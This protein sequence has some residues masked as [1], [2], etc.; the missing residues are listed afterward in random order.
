MRTRGLPCLCLLALACSTP[1]PPRPASAPTGAAPEV[2]ADLPPGSVL[3]LPPV[4]VVGR[5]AEGE[6]AVLSGLWREAMRLSDRFDVAAG[7][8]DA[9]AP[10]SVVV[11]LDA[12]AATLTSSLYEEGR[13]PVAL[14]ATALPPG[15]EAEAIEALASQTRYALG[16]TTPSPAARLRLLYSGEHAC[17]AATEAALAAA[18]DGD[19]PDARSRLDDARRADAGCTITLLA[20]AELSLRANDFVRARR[21]AQD[22]LQLTNRGAP[23]TRH[24]LARVLLLARAAHATGAETGELDR[25]LLALGERAVESRPHDPHTRWTLAQA[26]SLVGRFEEAAPMLSALRQR[27]PQ[28]TQVPYHHAL[29][30]LGC[31][32]P[33]EALAAL[34]AV[35]DRLAPTQTAIPHAIALWAAGRQQELSRL[36]DDLVASP[37]VRT[38]ALL[39]H[40]R[41]MQAAQAILEERGDDA[42]RLLL[43]DLEWMRQR[44][45]RLGTYAEQLASTGQVLV[46]LG[47]A[48]EVT[49]TVAAFERLPQLDEGARRALMFAGGL[50]ATSSA[51]S[52]ASTAEASLGK[53]GESAWSLQLRAAAHRA[54]GELAEEARALLQ[55]AR[56]DRGPLLRA[57]LAR[58]LRTAGDAAQAKSILDA[59][60]ADLLRLDLRRLAAH[61]LVDPAN[62]LALLATR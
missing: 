6:V 2:L 61:P 40:V 10:H 56:L 30:L 35:H 24:R 16:D 54:R 22:A 60:R 5:T 41:R 14:A 49:R 39:H 7:I 31:D 1:Q 48:A 37:D 62:A 43:T 47:H 52:T 18:V 21:V 3:R 55:A 9:P 20:L 58:T 11:H 19:L 46:L 53:E 25:E 57:S 51:P 28:V 33:G 34:E 59:L 42:A 32:R 44:T 38:S 27:W 29:A 4:E 8:E 36:L 17:V 26:L 23:S 50:A 12:E 15:G 45:S 13:A